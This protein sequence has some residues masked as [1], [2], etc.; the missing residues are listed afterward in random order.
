M[1]QIG[2]IIAKKNEGGITPDFKI[3]E[4]IRKKLSI[5]LNVMIRPW[6][7]FCLFNDEL[8]Q[9][10]EILEFKIASRWFCW[11]FR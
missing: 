11:D 4:A 9:M 2:R 6:R 3:I 10:T 1:G 5:K 8:E 7:R